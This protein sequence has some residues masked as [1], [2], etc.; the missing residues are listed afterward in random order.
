M[1]YL[2]SILF[3]KTILSSLRNILHLVFKLFKKIDHKE[4]FSLDFLCVC[5]DQ[6]ISLFDDPHR[7]VNHFL[8]S[9]SHFIK[10]D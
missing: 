6:N 7:L 5:I 8:E 10:K 1:I 4:Y 9:Q 3:W 2:S